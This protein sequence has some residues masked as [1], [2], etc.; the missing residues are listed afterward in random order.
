MPGRIFWCNEPAVAGVLERLR[1][2]FNG[3]V[4]IDQMDRMPKFP[5]CTH[6]IVLTISLQPT[7]REE[8]WALRQV[9]LHFGPSCGAYIDEEGPY[10]RL[11]PFVLELEG[12]F[13]RSEAAMRLG[14]A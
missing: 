3:S 14:A 1:M 9:V 6:S 2:K 7:T 13:M 10:R 11:E 8:D 5:W 4:R 12:W